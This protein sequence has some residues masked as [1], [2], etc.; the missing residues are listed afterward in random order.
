MKRILIHV[1][2]KNIDRNILR[3]EVLSKLLA[4]P[5][6][7]K[8]ILLVHPR[9]LESDQQEYVH[10]KLK[11]CPFPNQNPNFT[12]LALWFLTKHTIHTNNVRR[13]IDEIYARSTG[14]RFGKYCIALGAFYL[15]QI[16]FV[17]KL[18][19]WVTYKVF[20]DNCSIKSWKSINQT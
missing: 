5:L 6:V 15:T 11:V 13:K 17:E 20:R 19:R 7:E 16:S 8:I 1:Y 14:F 2:D 12:E 9:K 10:T 18:V 4:D 3:T